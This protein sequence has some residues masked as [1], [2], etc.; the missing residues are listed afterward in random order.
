MCLLMVM[1]VP[2]RQV[3]VLITPLCTPCF[4]VSTL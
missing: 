4:L 2:R 3:A 1:L